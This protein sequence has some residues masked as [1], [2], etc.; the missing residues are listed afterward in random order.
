MT[1]N[2]LEGYS[3]KQSLFEINVVVKYTDMMV[4]Q[5]RHRNIFHA[6]NLLSNSNDEHH[7]SLCCHA[8]QGIHLKRVHIKPCRLSQ[9][10]P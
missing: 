1:Q 8:A 4:V 7:T 10:Y 9:G 3:P 6:V 2:R 5:F